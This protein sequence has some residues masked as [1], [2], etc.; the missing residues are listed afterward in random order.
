MNNE[1][2]LEKNKS[3]AEVI[4]ENI[5]LTCSP[6]AIKLID[7]VKEVPEDIDL[8]DSKMRHCEMVRKAS[9]GDKFYSTL[10][11]QTCLG[12][13]GAIGLRD[14]PP[15]LASGEKYYSLGRFKDL[16]TAKETA[17][18]LSIIPDR[19]YG[20]IYAPLDKANFEPDVIIILSEP[21]AAMKIAQAL[22]YSN[23][24]KV[25][26]SF[27]GIQSL[28]GDVVANPIIEKKV[29]ITMGCDGSR[30][31]ADIKD[32]ELAIG[33]NKENIDKVIENLKAI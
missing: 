6:V 26:P 11:Q 8:I 4:S 2:I 12:G 33:I 14:M 19:H 1:K 5:K 15:K 21:V 13:A 10:D 7:D 32:E 24:N 30:K 29:N 31:E 20:I 28:C 3:D 27:A 23:G 25:R 17:E 16:K 18:K 22:V 9:Y